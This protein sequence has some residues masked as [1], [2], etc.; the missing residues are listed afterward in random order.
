MKLYSQS[1]VVD[2][3]GTKTKSLMRIKNILSKKHVQKTKKGKRSRENFVDFLLKC[4]DMWRY[5]CFSEHL[6]DIRIFFHNL[7]LL[8][9]KGS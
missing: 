1:L 5:L 8:M 3:K 9:I 6:V 4:A 7:L 2:I